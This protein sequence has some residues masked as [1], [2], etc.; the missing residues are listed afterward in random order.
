VGGEPPSTLRSMQVTYGNAL[1]DIYRTRAN[2]GG[3]NATI[4]GGV[5]AESAKKVV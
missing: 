4:D 5:E 3:T 1:D 2:A